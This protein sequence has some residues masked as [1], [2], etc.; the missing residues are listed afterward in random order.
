[1]NICKAII[2]EGK[3]K[4]NICDK[5]TSNEHGYCGKH[6]RN[7]KYDEGIE[8]GIRWCRFFF[9]GC[10]NEIINEPKKVL[11]CKECLEAKKK[12]TNNCQ[13]EG[14]TFK[15]KDNEL[16]CGKHER[17]KYRLEEKEKGFR[18]C[19]IDRGCFTICNEDMSSCEKCLEKTREKDN[20]RNNNRKTI[21]QH[22]QNISNKRL[23]HKCGIEFETFKTSNNKDSTKCKKCF[24][25][26]Q[27]IED[28]RDDRN[29]NYKEERKQFLETHFKMFINESSK[30][31]YNVELNFEDYKELITKSCYYCNHYVESEAI[32][33]DRINNSLGYTKE[34]CV[35]CCEICNRIKSFYHPVF[36]INKIKIICNN[37]E[38]DNDFYKKWQIYYSRSIPNNYLK[39][40]KEAEEKRSLKFKITPNEWEKLIRQPCYLCGY[41]QAVGIG[42]DRVDNTIR[43]YTTENCKPCCGSCNNMKN[44]MKYDDFINHCNKIAKKWNN[45]TELEVIPLFNNPLKG[46]IIVNSDTN[47]ITNKVKERKHWTRNGLYQAILSNTYDEFITKY[48]DYI[49]DNEIE[50][51]INEVQDETNKEASI[52]KLATFLNTLNVRRKRAKK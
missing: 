6:L 20:K 40:K 23:C 10:D 47:E 1:M 7:K 21:N 8:N 29:R 31:G 48:K 45:I 41:F 13:H 42:L 52:Q 11:T 51:I 19:D 43:E 14:C 46:N 28:N 22:L 50:N 9:R 32:G 12:N 17:D 30:R 36:F 38:S 3:N 2:Q 27:K 26:Q 25:S 4:G 44:E 18:Y 49:K 24:E 5:N 35:P 33:I 37:I 34:N 39:Y 16:F 15:A